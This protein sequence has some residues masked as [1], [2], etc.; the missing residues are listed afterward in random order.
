MGKL[1]FLLVKLLI[2]HLVGVDISADSDSQSSPKSSRSC[3]SP[4]GG[5]SQPLELLKHLLQPP[6][7]L[8]KT[9]RSGTGLERILG[10][11]TP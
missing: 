3:S 5:I 10:T 11:I 2:P 8:I 9:G 4:G 1:S 6:P 7:T